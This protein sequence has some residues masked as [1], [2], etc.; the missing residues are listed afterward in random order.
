MKIHYNNRDGIVFSS[1]PDIYVDGL[2][3]NYVDG[4]GIPYYLNEGSIYLSGGTV[5]INEENYIKVIK[6][7]T[8]YELYLNNILADTLISDEVIGGSENTLYL[9]V[10]QDNYYNSGS[11]N[12]LYI[13]KSTTSTVI[14]NDTLKNKTDYGTNNGVL[15]L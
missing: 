15:F 5:N 12:N 8:T 4:N 6:S 11:I 1:T 2:G 13:Y 7:G 14:L 9:G 10:S 3:M